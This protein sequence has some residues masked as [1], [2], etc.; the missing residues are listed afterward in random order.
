MW[1]FLSVLIA[2]IDFLYKNGIPLWAL[3]RWNNFITLLEIHCKGV[4]HAIV[5]KALSPTKL[6]LVNIYMETYCSDAYQMYLSFYCQCGDFHC[7]ERIC[8]L[9][10]FLRL[11]LSNLTK[12]INLCPGFF[13]NIYFAKRIS[14][15][16]N[17]QT[18]LK[19]FKI[20]TKWFN[21]KASII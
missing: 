10:Y 3:S 15:L 14:S 20:K 21:S 6:S 1:G 13:S 7:M 18:W 9:S 5:N 19:C 8:H 16:P 12:K 2:I 4:L 17:Q 11:P